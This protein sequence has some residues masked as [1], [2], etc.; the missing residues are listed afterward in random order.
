MKLTLRETLIVILLSSKHARLSVHTVYVY[1][2]H[3][4]DMLH[5]AVA[6]N[7]EFTSSLDSY[8]VEHT[9]IIMHVYDMHFYMNRK[10]IAPTRCL[11]LG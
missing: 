6:L 7:S 11:T 3:N 4:N 8:T 5:S 10:T 9:L 1:N 2:T